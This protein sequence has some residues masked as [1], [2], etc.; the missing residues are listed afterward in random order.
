M[1]RKRIVERHHPV[2]TR[3]EPLS[4]LSV[5]NGEFAFSADFTGLQTFPEL[6][7]VPLGTQSNWSWHYSGGHH[8]YGGQDVEYQQYETYGRKVG[9]PMKPGD[10]E[11]AYHWLRQN[12]HRLQL[13]RIS[14]RLLHPDGRQMEALEVVPVRQELNLWTG[15]LH[16][17]F[18]AG[19]TEVH[20]TT[21][22]HPQ[23]DCLGIRVESELLREGQL[24]VF[25]RFPAPDMTHRSW[26]KSVF[27]DWGNDSR[28]STRLAGS[29]ANSVRL[30]RAMDEDG[31]SVQWQWSAGQLEQTGA[32]EFTLRPDSGGTVFEFAA[33]FGLEEPHTEPVEQILAASAAHWEAFWHSGAAVSFEGSADPRAAEL[34][35]RVVLSQFLCALHSA[36][37]LPPQETG[38]MYNSWFGKLHL[39]MHW[40][41][42]AHFPLWGRAELLRKSMDWYLSI[43]PRARELARSQGYEGARWPKMVGP[44]GRQTPSP[45]APALIWQQPHPMVLAELCYLAEP[46]RDLLERYQAIVFEA[47]DFMVSYAHWDEVRQAYVL[48]PPLIPAQENHA[49]ELSMNPPYELEYWRFGLEIA[50]KWAERLDVP[51]NPAWVRVADSMAKP[52][53]EEGVY[54]AHEHC[55]DTFTAKNHDHPS[56][57]GALGLLPGTLIDRDIMRNTLFKVKECWDWDS[58]WG[59]D[60]PMCAMTAARLGERE[61]AVDFLLMDAV[62]N[63]YLPNGHNYQRPGLWAYLPG[64]G[65]LLTAVA[66]MAAGWAS[67]EERDCPGFPTDGWSVQWEGLQPWL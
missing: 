40:W 16:S 20:V 8:V 2:L 29:S 48:G 12:P 26:S 46:V 6:Y 23:Q 45:V 41:H 50:V 39:E 31:Y 14:F 24:H 11:D 33:A 44:D 27:P 36:G 10:R 58:A 65:G 42:A 18:S 30:K 43:L 32:H 17:S 57:V 59:W 47:A 35:R 66:M 7:E 19:G 28:H 38:L 13:G 53:Q 51:A 34:E 49:M 1:D 3:L 52:R 4:P 54:L 56:M 62:K 21:A 67:G 25:V 55:L 64:N 60:F 22:C 9:Y 61:L 5:G 37:S 15:T 63:T